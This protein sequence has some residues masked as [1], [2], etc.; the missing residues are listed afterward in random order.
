M[1]FSREIGVKA[2]K[3]Y[4]N[5]GTLQ[6]AKLS[7]I[8]DWVSEQ[9]LGQRHVIEL[10]FSAI[11]ARGHVL[12]EGPPGVGKTT[13]AKTIAKSISGTFNRIQMTNDMLPSDIT[14]VLRPVDA[15]FSHF[16]LRK[17]PIFAN[18]ILADELNRTSPK[19]QAALLEAMGEGTVSVDGTSHSLPEPF[20]VLA[21]QNPIESY[22]VFPLSESQL[23]RF[24]LKVAITLPDKK[25]ELEI[26]RNVEKQPDNPNPLQQND[27]RMLYEEI[28]SVF[29]HEDILTYISEISAQT[30]N[31]ESTK[32][33]VSVRGALQ[34]IAC[35]KALAYIRK[36]DFVSPQ[37]VKDLAAPALAHRLY[38]VD[39]SQND[40][41]KNAI[42]NEII[43]K[44]PCPK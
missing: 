2:L 23:D 3:E 39:G 20:F 27:L 33:G 5:P 22:G 30:R 31:L 10:A 17:G 35:T 28:D 12:L 6:N 26:Y 4:S 25:T 24:M 8:I 15:S 43:Q 19:T 18:V 42:I 14:G 29:V 16:E 9:V 41:Q 11:L 38:L 1:L 32:Y 34:F 40:D 7:R 37:E 44:I 21:T 13:L 36:K